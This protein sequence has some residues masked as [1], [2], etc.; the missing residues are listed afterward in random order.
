[1]M[2]YDDFLEEV[3]RT[4]SADT[5]ESYKFSLKC[6]PEGTKEEVLAYIERKD[7]ADSTKK[8]RLVVLK[9]A[10]LYIGGMTQDIHRLISGYRPNVAV[11]PCPTTADVE[12]LWSGLRSH[13]DKLI[14]ALMA[15]NGLRVSEVAGITLDDLG[16]D[17]VTLRGTKGKRDAV[18]PL[19]HP[20]VKDELAFY[21][22]E[23]FSDSSALFIG[24]RGAMT[25]NGIKQVIN[26]EF[27]DNEM[28]F[29]C[30][31]LR[32]YYAN[33]LMN[34]GVSL[35]KLCKCMRHSSV[36]TTMRYLNISTDDVKEALEAA[37]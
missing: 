27:K 13:R 14:V 37:V 6:F 34:A 17:T 31:S 21:L 9:Q 1:M 15:Y 7:I 23:R 11:Q 5:Y 18:I 24:V 10:L 20:R 33:T 35:E 30:H 4:R 3:R 26:K 16:N 19:V 28:P 12:K 2:K 32:R 29:H 8:L 25:T 22:K 36:T